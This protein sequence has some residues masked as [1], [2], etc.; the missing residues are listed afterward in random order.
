M[1]KF[2]SN[3]LDFFSSN[4]LAV[5]LL[6]L[7]AIISIFGTIIPQK[8]PPDVYL[9]AYGEVFSSVFYFL[10]FTDLFGSLAFKIII[11][12]LGISLTACSYKRLLLAVQGKLDIYSWG[13]FFSHLSVLVIYAGVIYGNTAGF[14][15]DI[16][17]EKG[18]SHFEHKG[19]F[20]VKLNDFN[21]KFD[22][23]GRPLDYTSDLSVIENNKEV[24]RKTIFVNNPLEYKGI[25][26]YQS[27]YGLNG[28]IEMKGPD[29]KTETIPIYRG[30]CATYSKTGYMF[31]IQ[32]FFPDL[33]ILHGMPSNV[34]EPTN[35]IVFLTT[36][37]QNEQKEVGWLLKGKTINWDG[38]ALKL[39]EAREYTG[40][41][42]KK[43]PGVLIVYV[44]FVLLILGSA[45]MLYFGVKGIGYRV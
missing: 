13:S 22:K 4:V 41:Q 32:E 33:H 6:V 23:E 31:H 28:I 45:I 35:P 18:S 17:I 25:K 24:V 10:N 42:V 16:A 39:V 40:L 36:Q 26:F 20:Y 3:L 30:G 21:A 15:S 27:S 37:D 14:S 12:L 29:G 38:Y 1:K 5:V 43:D 8:Q 44:G 34:Y 9:K 19:N 2:L 7:T 11:I